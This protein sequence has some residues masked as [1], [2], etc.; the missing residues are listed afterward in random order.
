MKT[1]I[2]ILLLLTSIT[3]TAQVATEKWVHIPAG[4]LA[5]LRQ[6]MQ[7]ASNRDPNFLTRIYTSGS[8]EFTG[9]TAGLPEINSH[10]IIKGHSDPISF[11]GAGE[12]FAN[13]FMVQAGGWL[14][15]QNI[16]IKDFSLGLE[17]YENEI[18]NDQSLIINHGIIELEEVQID[19]LFA[20]SIV[21][22]PTF[23]GT[24]LYAPIITNS[25]SG[26]LQ[27][28][29]VS[30]LDSGTGR[31]GGLIFSNGSVEIQNTQVYFSKD[32]PDSRVVTGSFMNNGYMSM[33]N[34][35]MFRQTKNNAPPVVASPGAE[36]YISNSIVSGFGPMSCDIASLGYN[37]I[38]YP[39]C[40]FHMEGDVVKDLVGLSW[41]PIELG[42]F[43]FGTWNHQDLQPILTHAL[44]P[45]A[46]SPAVDSINP[47]L[48]P[49]DHLLHYEGRNTDGN[50]DG[51]A[52]CDM[53]A[54]ELQPVGL[55]NG[56]INGVYFNPDADG[57]Y[58]SIIDN[59]YNTLIMWN[60]FDQDGNQYFVHGTGELVQ[61]RSLIADAYITVSG[62]TSSDGEIVPA[63]ELH[64]GT[65]EVDMI[66][67]NEGTLA[68]SSDFPEVGSGQVRLHR[69][70]F[71]K[72]LGCVD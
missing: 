31:D 55:V 32:E 39:Q 2:S 29:Q 33:R 27:L 11:I 35:S 59:P 30:I 3:V 12:D 7:E 63:E 60:S 56:G 10:V 20:W 52:K 50:A 9:A 4:D 23:G 42:P 19:S 16:E 44:V 49:P 41:R 48:C 8:F 36:T 37:L 38:E 18:R 22:K 68:F 64:W 34:I 21:T 45:F 6:V 24:R 58:I 26:Q 15:L 40:N 46:T 57:H 25:V 53:G 17:Q 14:Q 61:G 65:L 69:L 28:N 47:E 5:A 43:A 72:Q 51:V 54:V 1:F 67:C 70:V 13:L 66:S 62:S 71:V